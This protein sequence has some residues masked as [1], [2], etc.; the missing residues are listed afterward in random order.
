MNRLVTERDV[1]ERVGEGPIVVD[2]ETLITPSALDLAHERG[3]AV[4]YTRGRAAAS[5]ADRV[6]GAPGSA[7]AP[8]VPPTLSGLLSRDGTYVLRIEGGKV[9]AFR[10]GPSGLEPVS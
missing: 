9:V 2:D 4:L 5:P 3:I 7:S 8:A 10:V 6:P 1:R